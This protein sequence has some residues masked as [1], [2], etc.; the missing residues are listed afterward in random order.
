MEVMG[1]YE[2]KNVGQALHAAY[3]LFYH[4]LATPGPQFSL[5]VK[6][7]D[8]SIYFLYYSEANRKKWI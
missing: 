1:L 6:W 7:H 5:T 4:G 3:H 2:G 8:G